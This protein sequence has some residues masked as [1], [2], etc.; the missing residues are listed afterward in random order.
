MVSNPTVKAHLHKLQY[1]HE[2]QAVIFVG[3][4]TIIDLINYLD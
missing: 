4:I 2:S 3:L 1:L